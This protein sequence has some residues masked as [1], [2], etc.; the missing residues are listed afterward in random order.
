MMM[1][2]VEHPNYYGGSDNPYEAI[3]VINAWGLGFSLG[4]AVKYI[5]RAG[6]KDSN[7]H[8]E[9]LEKAAF[10]IK[11]EIENLKSKNAN[12]S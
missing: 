9:D 2:S 12:R 10:Y 4:S 11:L 6:S 7:K 8:I 5:C 3:K 1:S